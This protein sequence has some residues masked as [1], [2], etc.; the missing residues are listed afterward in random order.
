[1]RLLKTALLSTTLLMGTPFGSGVQLLDDQPTAEQTASAEFNSSLN[2]INAAYAQY[3]L[4]LKR[5]TAKVADEVKPEDALDF[6]KT[7]GGKRLN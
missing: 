3:L 7:L 1:M 2:K 5:I 6:T 4:T